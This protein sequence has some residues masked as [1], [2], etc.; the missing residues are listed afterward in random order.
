MSNKR[1]DLRI[2]GKEYHCWR[3]GKYIGKATWTDDENIGDSFIRMAIND[4]NELTHQVFI[5]DEWQFV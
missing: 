3:E 5:P 1:Q 4:T 2:Y